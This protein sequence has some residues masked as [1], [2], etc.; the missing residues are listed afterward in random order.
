MPPP[1]AILY[2]ASRAFAFRTTMSVNGMTVHPLTV[3][4]RMPSNIPSN[5]PDAS[6]PRWTWQAAKACILLVDLARLDNLG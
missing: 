3:R 6:K 4:G 2:G 5:S 1:S